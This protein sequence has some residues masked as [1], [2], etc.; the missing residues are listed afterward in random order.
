M[1]IFRCNPSN[2]LAGVRV[3]TW[4]LTV[5]RPHHP[6]VDAWLSAVIKQV[7]RLRNRARSKKDYIYHFV[8]C[9]F[10]QL[11]A[12]DPT[13]HDIYNRTPLLGYCD[14]SGGNA[15]EFCPKLNSHEDTAPDPQKL[16][17][18]GSASLAKMKFA[19]YDL[20]ILNTTTPDRRR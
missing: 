5:A 3:D 8:H 13:V 18:K 14:Q 16:M 12:D 1:E 9:I 15:V 19:E 20:W 6:L 17:Y 11:Y 10:N 7:A 2:V 4:F